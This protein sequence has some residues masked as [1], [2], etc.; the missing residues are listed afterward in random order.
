MA[1]TGLAPPASALFF[2]SRNTVKTVLQTTLLR[3]TMSTEG[4]T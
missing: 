1:A 3:S 2:G 4:S